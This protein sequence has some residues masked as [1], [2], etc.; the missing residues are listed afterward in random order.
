MKV[1]IRTSEIKDGGPTPERPNRLFE[2]ND[3]LSVFYVFNTLIFIGPN[4]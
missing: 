1:E 4:Y 3:W 2:L